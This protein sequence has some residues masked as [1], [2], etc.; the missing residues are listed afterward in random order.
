MAKEIWTWPASVDALEAAPESHRLL[1]ENGA[2]RVLDTR[3]APGETTPVHTHRWPGILYILTL[4]HFVRRD[5]EGVILVD[6]RSL[7]SLPQ[8]GTAI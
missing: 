7:G 3:I 4:G 6:T 8:A 2:V 1:F 5:A